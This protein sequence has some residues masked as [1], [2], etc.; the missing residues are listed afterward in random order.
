MRSGGGP[1]G[2]RN[3]LDLLERS[4]SPATF[5]RETAGRR[6][7]V[8]RLPPRFTFALE[9]A[10]NAELERRLLE[11]ELAALTARWHEEEE[12]A[13]II[14]RELTPAPLRS[15]GAR[16]GHGRRGASER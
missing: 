11:M 10:L 15:D 9:I 8:G 4:G 2:L 1:A 6:P 12:L 13:A 5:L 14:D 7:A 3:A 16:H